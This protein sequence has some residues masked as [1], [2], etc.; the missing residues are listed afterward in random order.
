[1]SI[2]DASLNLDMHH[3]QGWRVV[4]MTLHHNGETVLLLMEKTEQPVGRR[5]GG[6]VAKVEFHAGE[7]FPRVGFIVTNTQLRN[8][9]VVHFYNQR[10]KAEQCIKEGKLAVKMTR[11]S[12]HRFRGG[13]TP[14]TRAV[15]SSVATDRDAAASGKLTMIARPIKL[16]RGKGGGESV[17]EMDKEGS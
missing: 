2:K 1:M 16:L 8:R 9:K 3:K 15:C 14:Y 11:L 13:R 4:Q 7:L 5:R 10:G 12:C 17:R 6:L